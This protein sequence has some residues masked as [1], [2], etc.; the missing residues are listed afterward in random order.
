MVAKVDIQRSKPLSE[1]IAKTIPLATP[2]SLEGET[3]LITEGGS[4]NLFADAKGVGSP[5]AS[6]SGAFGY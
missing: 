5:A 6:D 3:A 2:F 1:S 4:L